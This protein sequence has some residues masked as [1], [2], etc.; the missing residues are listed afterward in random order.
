M[1]RRLVLLVCV[2]GLA[3]QAAAQTVTDQRVWAGLTLQ[4]RIG[5]TSPWRWSL[6][7]FARS[8][9]VVDTVDVAAVRP[10][11]SYTLSP[12]VSLGGGY[13]FAPSFPA[14]GGTTIE[15]RFFGQIVIT[16]PAASGT[17][18]LRSRIEDRLIEGNSG[19]L[20]RFRQQLRFSRAIRKGGRVAVVT[21][22]E[23][24]VHLNTTTRSP[25]G[26]DQ[27]RFFAGISNTLASNVRVEVGYVN[28]FSPGHSGAADRMN[29]VLSGSFAVSF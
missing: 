5:E 23:L 24:L 19:P 25:R 21:Y 17:I 1:L 11:I 27:N 28:Q 12:T 3:G 18:T 14:A 20:G 7:A 9:D 26:V 8:R 6:E 10:T 15:H 22:D 13:A 29:H 2:L 16:I 4:G